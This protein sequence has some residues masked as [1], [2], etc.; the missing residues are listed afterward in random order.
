MFIVYGSYIILDNDYYPFGMIMLGRV[1]SSGSSHRYGFQNQERDDEIKGE[2]NSINYK[3]RIHDPRLGRFLSID[4]KFKEYPFYSPYAFS[5]N[6]VIDAI[7]LEGLQ[8][9]V[10]FATQDAAANDFGMLF[11]D[12]SIRANREYGTK[13]YQVVDAN[14]VTKFTYAIPVVGQPAGLTGVQM[15][16]LAVPAGATVT[17]FAHTH[18]AST[19]NA[20]ITYQDNV[21][22]GTPGTTSGGGDI[23]FAESFGIDGYVSTPNGS[24]QKYDVATNQISTLNMNQPQDSGP[25]NGGAGTSAPSTSTYS[26]QKGD[27]LTSIA[28]RYNTTVSAIASENKISDPNMIQAGSSLNIRN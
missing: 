23:G 20:P 10:L 26:I 1:W 15:A 17:A 12:N 22:S 14:N 9:G 27:T 2:G 16:G 5:G 13:I 25:G 21:F 7:E 6:R 18:A 28:K 11:G 3:Y 4:P 24:L 19:A 8:P